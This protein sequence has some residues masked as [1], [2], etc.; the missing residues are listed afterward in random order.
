MIKHA[1]AALILG[2]S[3]LSFSAP[4]Q[5]S[6]VVV[7]TGPR[8]VRHYRPYRYYYPYYSSYYYSPY[9]SSYYYPYYSSYYYPSYYYPRY[10]Y[11]GASFYYR[12]GRHH[13]GGFTVGVGF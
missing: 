4:A 5:A 12:G 7:T 11:P 8:V 2:I 10:Y 6:E 9:Y 3:A 1:L 13:R